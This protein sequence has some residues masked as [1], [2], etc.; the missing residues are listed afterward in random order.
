MSATA[1]EALITLAVK[2][3][4]TAV[5]G[6]INLFKKQNSDGTFTLADVEAAF[7]SL[8]KYEGYGIPDKVPAGSPS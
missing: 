5:E 8:K 3:G 4:P 2:Y 1:V 7:T 6:I